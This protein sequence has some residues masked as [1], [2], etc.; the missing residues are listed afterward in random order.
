MASAYLERCGA[1]WKIIEM[2]VRC[3]EVYNSISVTSTWKIV[4]NC[5]RKTKSVS[6]GWGVLDSPPVLY[7][8]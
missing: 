7:Y 2:D 4:G 5:K 1:L 8:G 3:Q 6:L